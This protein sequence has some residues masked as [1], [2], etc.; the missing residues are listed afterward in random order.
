MS[1]YDILRNNTRK[2]IQTMFY[3]RMRVL[4]I[5]LFMVY[6]L[7]CDAY[8][9]TCV[10]VLLRQGPGA[11]YGQRGLSQE[12]ALVTGTVANRTP[13]TENI[14]YVWPIECQSIRI[15]SLCGQ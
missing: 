12:K 3:S 4:F 9:Y 2:L 15:Y 7:Y 13:A 14:L 6:E 8:I 10:R 1:H 5:L 11:E